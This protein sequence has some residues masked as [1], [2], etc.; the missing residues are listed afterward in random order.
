MQSPRMSGFAGNP[1][2]N[3]ITAIL[4]VIAL[5]AAVVFS[6]AAFAIFA[7]AALVFASVVGIRLWWLSRK[8]RAR[9]APRHRPSPGAVIDVEYEVLDRSRK[10]E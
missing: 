8:L 2:A 10:S 4:G 5:G 6:L 9:G 7:I 3:A 1:V